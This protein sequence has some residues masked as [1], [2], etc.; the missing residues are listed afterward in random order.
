MQ[1]KSI[2]CIIVTLSFM[3]PAFSQ[4]TTETKPAVHEETFKTETVKKFIFE[5]CVAGENLKIKV[6]CPTKGWVSVGF[7]PVKKMKGADF[8]IGC[9]KKKEALVDDQF[10]DSPYSHKSDIEAGGKNNILESTCTETAGIT[11][12]TFTIPLNSGDEK[13]SVLEKGKEITVILGAGKKDD[14]HSKHFTLAKTKI[15]L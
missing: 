14:F 12:L 9:Y 2:L 10:G 1:K 6:S 13:D 5:Y 15:V 7:N 3:L 4:D 11:T 8:I